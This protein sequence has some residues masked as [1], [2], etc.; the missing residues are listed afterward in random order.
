[1]LPPQHRL[2]R[3]A[4]VTLVNQ[5]GRRLAH[6]L[7]V[8]LAMKRSAADGLPSRFAFVAGRRVGGAVIRNRAKRRLRETVRRHLRQLKPG[9]D[10]VLFARAHTADAEFDELDQAVM[11]LLS[12]AGVSYPATAGPSDR[13]ASGTE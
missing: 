1:M 13:G 8:V 5:R 4:D 9:M 11:T 6:P 3:S 12:R 2:R 7:V 10:I